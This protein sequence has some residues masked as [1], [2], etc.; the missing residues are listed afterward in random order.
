MG[1]T[2]GTFTTQKIACIRPNINY[3][4]NHYHLRY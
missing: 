1:D 2:D 4:A 3:N